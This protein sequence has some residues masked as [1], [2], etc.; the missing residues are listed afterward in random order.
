MALL[1]TGGSPNNLPVAL[2]SFVG[3]ERELTELGLLLEA[4]RQLTLTGPGGCG[5]TRLA[6]QAASEALE[7]FPDGAWWVELAPLTEAELVGA[8]IG[9][10]LGVRPFPGMTELQACGADLA[11]RRALVVLDNCE[12]CW[13]HAPAPPSRS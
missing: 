5:K 8:A 6:L 9:E 3:R 11:S 7:R 1:R 2:S 12:I 13:R 10:A 4:E